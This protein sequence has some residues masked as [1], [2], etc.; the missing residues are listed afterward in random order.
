MKIHELNV[1]IRRE[2]T[3]DDIEKLCFKIYHN[4]DKV[5]TYEERVDTNH[6][7]SFY[8]YIFNKAK[9]IIQ[10]KLEQGEPK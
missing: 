2:I 4:N 1:S 9:R 7:I 5:I 8:D 10:D 3:S 6:L